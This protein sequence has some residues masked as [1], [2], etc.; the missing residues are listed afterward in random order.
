MRPYSVTSYPMSPASQVKNATAGIQ[1]D[2]VERFSSILKDSVMKVACVCEHARWP[3]IETAKGELERFGDDD[4]QRLLSHYEKLFKDLGGDASKVMRE[5]SE[6]AV[7]EG[8]QRPTVQDA[9]R[10]ATR[11]LCGQGE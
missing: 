7:V 11:S 3:S 8:A 2:L 4:I 1:E 5:P 9:L 6:A 10:A